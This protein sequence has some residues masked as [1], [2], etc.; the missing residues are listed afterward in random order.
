MNE[1]FPDA[2][3]G[4]VHIGIVDTEIG[5]EEASGR[6]QPVHNRRDECF[7]FKVTPISCRGGGVGSNIVEDVT[8]LKR[9]SAR[10]CLGP[11]LVFSVT[12]SQAPVNRILAEGERE[13]NSSAIRFTNNFPYKGARKGRTGDRDRNWKLG[14]WYTLELSQSIFIHDELVCDGEEL[15]GGWPCAWIKDCD[16]GPSSV[17]IA[18]LLLIEPF[19][20]AGNSARFATSG[21]GGRRPSAPRLGSDI[22]GKG[23]VF[24][25][26]LDVCVHFVEEDSVHG[27]GSRP[28][29]VLVHIGF[30]L[31][32][33]S[34][35]ISGGN[36]TDEFHDL[37]LVG[38][39]SQLGYSG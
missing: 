34:G 38:R 5:N 24:V 37:I 36:V 3:E 23:S 28:G 39:G 1:L 14:E 20:S 11:A 21:G 10:F 15:V 19:D 4:S 7:E 16:V 32:N 2:G 6:V 12:A 35:S 29:R 25:E 33:Q 8:S 9:C 18:L 30:H 27:R 26:Y 22:V 31:C 17:R 13:D